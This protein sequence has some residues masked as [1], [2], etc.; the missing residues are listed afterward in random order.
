MM[1]LQDTKK[2]LIFGNAISNA[3]HY[4]TESQESILMS[5]KFI[6]DIREIEVK[7][8]KQLLYTIT[9]SAVCR[10]PQQNRK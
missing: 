8:L 5:M 3:N 4:P 10:V 2:M 7:E 9:Q 1:N 6:N